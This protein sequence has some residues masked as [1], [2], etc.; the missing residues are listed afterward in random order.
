MSRSAAEGRR[1]IGVLIT[2][3]APRCPG[4]SD[5]YLEAWTSSSA[6]TSPP[7][8]GSPL[9]WR[10]G[11]RP[12]RGRHRPTWPSVLG[13]GARRS[14]RI[15][16][17]INLRAELLSQSLAGRARTCP[18]AL[19]R[20]AVS[21]APRSPRSEPM[22]FASEHHPGRHEFAICRM[23]PLS[24][25]ICASASPSR[26]LPDSAHLGA[27]SRARRRVLPN[28]RQSSTPRTLSAPGMT[29]VVLPHV[30]DRGRLACS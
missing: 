28:V 5:P 14:S 20:S 18:G 26:P 29:R 19:L 9:P 6:S 25:S 4:F 3:P 12:N 11:S 13:A 24:A 7:S 22:P 30:S 1:R 17:A 2:T 10:H 15:Y 16:P 8:T 21:P 27:F 23:Q